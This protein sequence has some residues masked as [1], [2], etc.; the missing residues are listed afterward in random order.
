[1]RTYFENLGQ[2]SITFVRYTGGACVLFFQTLLWVPV[3]PTRFKQVMDQMVKVGVNSFPICSLTSFFI[4]VVIAFQSAYQMQKVN[5]QMYIP[6]LV[7]ISITREIGPIITSLVVAGRVG[8]AIAAEIGS[9]KATEQIDALEALATNPVKYLVAPRFLALFIML[10]LLTI[11]ADLLGILGGYVVSIYK[12]GLSHAVYV[13]MAFL[14]LQMKDIFTG[15]AKTLVF[16]MIIAIIACYEG[17]KVEGGAEG[18]GNATTR[19]VVLSFVLII[20]SDALF[21]YIFYFVN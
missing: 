8:A 5:A 11:Y 15:L 3:M 20:M 6:S 16:A 13:R 17:M 7:A 1:M 19:A 12:L 9:M 10:P 4:G 21:T 14:P 2:R 18:V